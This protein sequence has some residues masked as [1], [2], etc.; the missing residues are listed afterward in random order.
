MTEASEWSGR[1]GDV[2]AEEWRRTDRGLADL[3]THLDAAVRNRMGDRS[4]AVG[5]VG[6]GAGATSI[7]TA[8]ANPNARVIGMDLSS[9]LIAIA[10]DRAD[11]LANLSFVTGPVEGSIPTTGPFDLIVSRHGVM[12]F[13]DPVAGLA[14]IRSGAKRGATLIFT[15]F[16]A[17]SVNA[18]A[19]EVSDAIS[20][21]SPV[22]ALG[23]APGPF[24][25]ADEAF[26][27][28]TLQAAGWSNLT[29]QAV[30]FTY[31]AGEG[32]NAVA[33]AVDFFTRIGPAARALRAAPADQHATI[34][35]RLHHLCAKRF[36]GQFVDFPAAAWLWSAQNL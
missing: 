25:F 21:T 24:A 7:S 31:R 33:D 14:A 36:D 19:S 3:A 17:P 15:C 23:Y 26:V 8:R 9:A 20:D 4:I 2:W 12:F 6:C 13:P 5:D 30:D 22:T 27:R 32:E 10:V 1:V 18:W 34:I 29:P 35:A 16:R 28:A 11:G